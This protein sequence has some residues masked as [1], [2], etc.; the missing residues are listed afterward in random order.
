MRVLL[1]EGA[2]E[3]TATSILLA[4]QEAETTFVAGEAER[5]G[6]V[7]DSHGWALDT[8]QAKLLDRA[9]RLAEGEQIAVGPPV[10]ET[11]VNARGRVVSIRG[12]GVQV[13]L[14]AGDRERIE[15]STTRRLPAVTTFPRRCVERVAAG[16][17]AA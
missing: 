4:P 3:A 16:E 14:D 17:G 7:V 2:E 12:D 9:P 1:K 5:N 8:S 11:F 10:A 6:I 13:E 15:R